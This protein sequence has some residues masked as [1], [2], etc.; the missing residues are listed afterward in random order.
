MKKT[1][2]TAAVMGIVG[3]TLRPPA[4]ADSNT[5]LY[6]RYLQRKLQAMKEQG[7]GVG[8]M[9]GSLRQDVLVGTPPTTEGRPAARLSSISGRP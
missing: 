4:N 1:I 6:Q 2:L 5:I 9:L 8:A 7:P 3:L